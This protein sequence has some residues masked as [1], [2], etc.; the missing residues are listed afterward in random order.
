MLFRSILKNAIEGGASDIHIEHIG[1]K[2]RVRY[3]VDGALHT[4]IMLP[5]NVHSGII[6]R[7]KVLSKLH[8]DEKRKPQDGSFSANI[9][10]RKI[11]FRVSTMPGNY[12]EKVA[13]RILDTAK[14]VKTLDQLGLSKRNTEMLRE[15][16]AKP[17][18]LILITGP[19]GSGKST[20]L[21]SIID[22]K[23][24]V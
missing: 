21:Y 6:A 1:S 15:A 8:L 3:R 11:D 17:Y 2:L 9:D 24:V 4:T 16:I 13:I 23:S 7:I 18:G 5:I 10:N 14:G 19:T 22:R 12:G 20:T